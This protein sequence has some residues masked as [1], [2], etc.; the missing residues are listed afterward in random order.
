MFSYAMLKLQERSF[1]ILLCLD[2]AKISEFSVHLLA[3]ALFS[4]VAAVSTGCLCAAA[5]APSQP[6]LRRTLWTATCVRSASC[7]GW[8]QRRSKGRMK[9][10]GNFL[11]N[12][13]I[14]I[15]QLCK[16]SYF[17]IKVKQDP[18]WFTNKAFNKIQ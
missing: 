11:P 1:N 7:V 14:L 4:S 10:T 12:A 16:L 18:N 13:E 2:L 9:A 6:N 17:F 3:P 5:Q 8:C 15:W